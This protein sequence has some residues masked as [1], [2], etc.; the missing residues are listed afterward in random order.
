MTTISEL[1]N[2]IR[3]IINTPRK[4][5]ALLQNTAAWNVLCSCLDVIGDTELSCDAFLKQHGVK[6]NGEKYLLVYGALQ[7]LFI[8]QDAVTNLAEAL[9]ISYTP[10]PL[11]KHIREIRNDSVGHPTK[12]GG[13]AGEAFNFIARISLSHHSFTLMTTY[14]DGRE[15]QILGVSVPDLINKQRTA[16]TKAL[17]DVV[18]KLKADEMEHRNKFKGEKLQ[19]I[20]PSTMGYYF[21][22]ISGACYGSEP[23]DLGAGV[24]GIVLDSLQRFKT[25]IQTRGIL[26]A[27]DSVTYY[28]DLIEYPLTELKKYFEK[29]PD[30]NLNSKSAYIFAFFAH[31]HMDTLQQI[32]KEIDEEYASEA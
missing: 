31:K 2:E 13:G 21:E 7:A 3:D 27:Y 11:L 10:D 23:I 1:E 14:P 28:L 8:Q 24:I 26:K 29:S 9:N 20:F 4:R 22:K 17:A 16:L 19:D 15:H 6:D 25:S 5:Y 30:S 18:I 32:A 12:R